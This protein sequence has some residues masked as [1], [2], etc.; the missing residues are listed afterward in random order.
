MSTFKVRYAQDRISGEY[1]V[2]DIRQGRYPVFGVF[3]LWNKTV[4]ELTATA[5]EVV[6]EVAKEMNGNRYKNY[7]MQMIR[8]SGLDRQ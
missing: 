8:V 7:S 4:A 6:A 5:R 1:Y 3:V 2:E